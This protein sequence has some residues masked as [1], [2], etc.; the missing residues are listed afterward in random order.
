MVDIPTW[1]K[2]LTSCCSSGKFALLHDAKNMHAARNFVERRITFAMCF[3]VRRTRDATIAHAHLILNGVV[4][5]IQQVNALVGL[6]QSPL[7]S[8]PTRAVVARSATARRSNLPEASHPFLRE[9]ATTRCRA[10][11]N[12]RPWLDSFRSRHFRGSEALSLR[13]RAMPDGDCRGAYGTSQ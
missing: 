1:A 2:W 4:S 11:R 6:R 7:G 9:I 10:P 12:D 13:H 5:D 3:L 8:R